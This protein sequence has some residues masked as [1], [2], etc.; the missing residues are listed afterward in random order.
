MPRPASGSRHLAWIE[1]ARTVAMAVVVWSHASNLVFF[2]E[3]NFSLLPLF[4]SCL[5]CFAVPAFLIISGYLTGLFEACRPAWESFSTRPARQMAKLLPPFLAWNAIS[6]LTLKGLYGVPLWSLPQA[7]DFLT[8]AVQ[9]YFIFVLLQILVLLRLVNLFATPRRL[10]RATL[11]AVGTTIGF[12]AFSTALFHL[13][14]PADHRFELVTIKWLPGW[15]GFFFLGAW[16][17]RHEHILTSLTRRL[18]LLAAA[19]ILG[20]GLFW[21]QVAAQSAA[22]GANYRQYFLLSGLAFQTVAALTL[23]CA[24]RRAEARGGG[25]MFT[26]LARCGRD[27][28]G[29]YLSHYTIVLAYYALVPPP[30]PPALRL[31]VALLAVAVSFAASLLLTRWVRRP[32]LS[33]LH[34]CL[35]AGS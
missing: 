12:Y 16:L 15:V 26:A 19:S 25:R 11:L 29:I 22:L 9:L 20:F 6:L 32:S 14:P 4:S 1:A 24:C 35:F 5:V 13:S 8:G 30:I 28:L 3:G 27:T 7:W 34:R 23:L 31:P 18:P 10:N 17:S 21:A 2:R 33:W